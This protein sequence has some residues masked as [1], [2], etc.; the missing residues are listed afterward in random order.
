MQ[1]AV[2]HASDLWPTKDPRARTEWDFRAAW[3]NRNDRKYPSEFLSPEEVWFC[4]RYEFH[5]TLQREVTDTLEWRME[6]W[7]PELT[8]WVTPRLR[9]EEAVEQWKTG[10][11]RTFDAL[12]EHWK[13]PRAQG[14]EADPIVM[15]WF[16]QVWP[17]WPEQP[18]LSINRKEREDQFKKTWPNQKPRVLP[19]LPL[20]KLCAARTDIRGCGS[21]VQ[22]ALHLFP[23]ERKEFDGET[24][25]IYRRDH[26]DAKEYPHV[27][28][29]LQIDFSVSPTRLAKRFENWCREK[30]RIKKWTAKPN[31]GPNSEAE[32]FRKELKCLG[33]WRLVQSGLTHKQAAE[34]TMEKSGQPLFADKSEWSRAV[35]QGEALLIYYS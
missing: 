35:K 16:Y 7:S 22:R 12:M 20:D 6:K 3:K 25:I 5:R 24:I 8:K 18:Y 17:Q 4:H 29:A 31:R 21:E 30:A 11:R 26:Q 33:A 28:A 2:K 23:N 13:R 1:A 19:A 32:R 10:H 14:G 27:I 9:Y 34:F 15:E